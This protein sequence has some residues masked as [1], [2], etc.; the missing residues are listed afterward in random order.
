MRA[1][2][3]G[4]SHRQQNDLHLEETRGRRQFS[5]LAGVLIAYINRARSSTVSSLAISH[6]SSFT[7]PIPTML[8]SLVKTLA[9]AAL[10]TSTYGQAAFVCPSSIDSYCRASNLHSDCVNGVFRSDAPDT[11]EECVC[12]TLYYPLRSVIL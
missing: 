5:S 8:L 7:I 3:I 2:C 12:G 6:R 11:C 4:P 9:L 10:F 1:S